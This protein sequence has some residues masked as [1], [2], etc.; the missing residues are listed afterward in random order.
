MSVFNYNYYK[1][2]KRPI[3]Y[4][5]TPRKHIIGT[6]KSYELQT[7]LYANAINS[8][9]FK[10]YRYENEQEI[11]NY[12]WVKVGMYVLLYG[13]DWFVISEVQIV[14]EGTNEYK[15]VVFKSLEHELTFRNITSLGSLG[16]DSDNQGGLDMYC[17]YSKTD[18]EHSILHM[19]V[20]K[21]PD[22]WIK[23]VDPAITSEYRSFN[24]DSIGTY[25]LL[26]DNCASTFD[27]IFSFDSSD[28]SISAYTLDHMGK[29]TGI[30]LNYRN[31]IKEVN[32][33][34]DDSNLKTVLHVSGGNDSRVNK[35][36]GIID[37]NISGSDQIYDFSYYLHMMSQE[38]QDGLKRYNNK[39]KEN[40]TAY[41]NGLVR[42]Q[43]L[44]NELYALN[45][46]APS[47]PGSTNW[48]EYGLKELQS[49]EQ[50]YWNLMSVNLNHKDP[51][52]LNYYNQYN[53]LHQ[54][55]EAEIVVRKNQITNKEAEIKK[56]KEMI[57]SL[58][59]KLDK[60]LG[61]E[62][63][64]ELSAYVKED[65]L[66]DD[67]FVVT[68]IMTDEEILKMQKSLLEHA[69]KE[70]KKVCYP[71]IE[72]EIDLINFT[73]D[74]DYKVFTDALEMFN[75]FH[76][77]L[78]NHDT[79]SDVRLLKLHINWDDPTDFT[80]T[81]S[82]QNNLDE[83]WGFLEE[84]KNQA[85]GTANKIEFASGAWRE[86]SQSSKE[87]KD[88]MNNV[89]V[90]ANHQIQNANNEE[91][92]IG[93]S[94]IRLKH[95]LQNEGRYDPC[96]A[97]IV[98]NTLCF[99]TDNWNTV[100]LA[101]G[102]IKVGNDYFYGLAA[103][104]ILGRILLS[105]QLYISNSSGTYTVDKNGMIAKNGSYQVKINPNT[106]S[107]IFSISIDNKKLLYV[108]AN[109]KK[110]KFEGDIESKSGHIA[111]FVISEK[112]LVSGNVG[113]S[114][115]TTRGAKAFWAGH[116]TPSSAPFW[117]DNTGKLHASNIEV[118]GGSI[119]VG[120]NFVVDNQGNMTAKNG[121]FTGTISG[122]SITG[123]SINIGD[124]F[125]VDNQG[126]MI[127]KSGTFS[128]KIT[129][130]TINIGNKFIVDQNGNLTAK[131]GTFSGTVEGGFIDGGSISIGNGIFEV[132]SDGSITM[133]DFLISADGTNVFKSKNNEFRIELTKNLGDNKFYS[134]IYMDT[135]HG[136][137]KI[138]NGQIIG[139]YMI[140]A[141]YI[142]ADIS[143]KYSY[144]YDIYLGKSWWEGWSITQTVEDLWEQVQS[145]SDKRVKDNINQISSSEALDFILS[146]NPITFQYKTN[147]KWSTG[148]VAQEV[149]NLQDKLGIYYPLVGTDKK[150]GYYNIK[151][152]NYIPLLVAAIQNL[153]D[154][155]NELKKS[156]T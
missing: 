137:L 102:H 1:N 14:N 72:S 123:S 54:A 18:T 58:V 113:M 117:V 101:L 86:N 99:T 16:T 43:I 47:T 59:V 38:L 42:L 22:W 115:D 30:I 25:E 84:I 120:N 87:F 140:E 7:D 147:G 79:I 88:F 124:K 81:F 6:I 21:N 33:K 116:T 134:S 128:G 65:T 130:S 48:S 10:V 80:A 152:R 52:Q 11:S 112:T 104:A 149:D 92:T 69:Q 135:I 114:S 111:S 32:Q 71:K 49:K 103:D 27:C 109:N 73:V 119:K 100:S 20:Q 122:S 74:Y 68:S 44:Y 62:L 144:F 51:T 46:K 29:D 82:N 90:A 76:I 93:E 66:T 13:V 96:Q 77:R 150:T 95:W 98:H 55:V 4:I 105:E 31:F 146:S 139:A 107:D 41:Q 156:S 53:K 37:V 24:I 9:S 56:C 45:N 83:S 15:E 94:G 131:S 125:I 8:G 67:S 36:I 106:P 57:Q 110:L 121:K 126:N 85:N 61:E 3:T 50:E 133:G 60:F 39:C 17:L 97:W 34:T 138:T 118:T 63:Y 23:Y 148:F 143:N 132:D 2:L 136:E 89:F 5:G 155:I 75:I 145:L 151:Y 12:N 26:T 91:I 35:P 28:K 40:E 70:L 19:V 108:D 153:Q 78:E 141:D 127:A 142:N 129:G 154:Q 64:R